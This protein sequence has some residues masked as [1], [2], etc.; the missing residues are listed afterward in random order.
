MRII[1]LSFDM[2]GV[3]CPLCDFSGTSLA[4]QIAVT[5]LVR[6]WEKQFQIDVSR[7]FQDVERLNLFACQRCGLQFYMPL[8]LAGSSDL[9]LQLE[10]FEWYYMPQK[11]EH[12]IALED[13]T[14][15]KRILEIGSGSGVFIAR[16]E[17][18][19]RLKV[20]GIEMNEQAVRRA[21][22]FGL[23]VQ[24]IELQETALRWPRH[25]DAV[26][27]FQVLEHVSRPKAFLESCCDLLKSGGRL[28]VG[29]PNA[30]SYLRYEFNPLD[31][32]PH[33][34]TKWSPQVLSY[35]SNL[36]PL[37]LV[38][39]KREPL[40]AYHIR[41][42]VKANCSSYA[43]RGVPKFLRTRRLQ[44]AVGGLIKAT[45]LHK[46]LTGQTLYASFRRI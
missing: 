25:Y 34:L 30:E 15:C 19:K 5:E 8:T 46:I 43:D 35:L 2:L 3:S 40:A 29:L 17:A 28:L 18:E 9:Y 1:T 20:E 13:L 14:D 42:Y 45:G 12:D 26:C 21:Q 10:K 16:A 37:R 36:L 39:I 44:R 33:H 6:A 24:S 41:Q 23:A 27:A 38:Q 32:P 22:R 31:M 7:D 11:W 4:K